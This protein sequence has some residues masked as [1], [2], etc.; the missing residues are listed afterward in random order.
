LYCSDKA[1][2]KQRLQKLQENL[3]IKK[4]LT[5]PPKSEAWSQKK[6]QKERKLKRKEIK[7]KK[8]QKRKQEITEEDLESLEDDFRMVK[9]LKNNKVRI[10]LY[11]MFLYL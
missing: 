3:E 7:E 2:E 10:Q 1:L 8:R 4:K 9:K 6:D 5:R 11:E